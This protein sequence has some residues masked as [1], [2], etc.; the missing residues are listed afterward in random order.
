MRAQSDAWRTSKDESAEMQPG[1]RPSRAAEEAATSEAVILFD[2]CGFD[3][4]KSLI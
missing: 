3:V 1:R 2:F 4:C